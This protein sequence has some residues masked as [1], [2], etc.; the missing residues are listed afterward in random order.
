MAIVIVLVLTV[1]IVVVAAW[2][3]RYVRHPENTD[4]P[5]AKGDRT[6][7]RFYSRVDRPAGPD[8]E[9]PVGGLHEFERGPDDG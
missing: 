5:R 4:P 2:A 1:V 7:D 3:A 6:S 9:D 8:A